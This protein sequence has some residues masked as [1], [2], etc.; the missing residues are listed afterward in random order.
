L[1]VDISKVGVV[2]EVVARF[3]EQAEWCSHLET[4]GSRVRNLVIGSV[5]D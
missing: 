5:D 3:Q 2:G 1:P 4:S